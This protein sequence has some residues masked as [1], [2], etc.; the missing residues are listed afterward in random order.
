[1]RAQ[2]RWKFVLMA[3][4]CWGM[5]AGAS[6]GGPAGGP[7]EAWPSERQLLLRSPWAAALGWN[8]SL[9]VCG[10][11]RKWNQSMVDAAQFADFMKACY[12][13]R[14]DLPDL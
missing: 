12:C 3:G 6:S 1:M 5:A 14:A 10:A 9:P 2:H 4:A 7:A 8:S 13:S 11:D